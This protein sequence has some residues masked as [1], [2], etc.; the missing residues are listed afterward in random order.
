MNKR[1]LVLSLLEAPPPRIPAAF[2]LHFGPGYEVGRAAI[3]RHLEYFRYTDIDF[4]KVQYEQSF[5]ALPRI[6]GPADWASMPLY[7]ESF[8]EPS[9]AVVRG[10]V[11]A[12]GS[13]ALIIVTLY[14]PF[15]CA[16]QAVGAE[17]MLRH[18][19]EDPEAV[20]RGMEIVAESLLNFVRG[21]VRLGV[22]GFYTSTQGGEATRL[23]DTRLFDLAVRPFDLLLMREAAARCPFNILHIC[24]FAGPYDE[25]ARFADYP[26]QVVNAPSMLGDRHF[27]MSAAAALFQR[28]VMGG[29]DRQGA[30]ARGDDEAI[31]AEALSTLAAAPERFMLGADCT[32]PGLPTWDGLRRAVRTAH[33]WRR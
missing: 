17:R 4:V 33:E 9:L 24:D 32:I 12:A 5:P 3:D 13:E 2:F 26:G 21:C 15:M 11:E 8:F 22:D 10:L 27:P 28:P 29:M 14:S 18:I 6:R 23:A 30:L 20:A 1:D 31:R 7:G 19:A 25:L 16:A